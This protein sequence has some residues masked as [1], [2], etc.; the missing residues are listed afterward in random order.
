MNKDWRVAPLDAVVRVE[1]RRVNDRPEPLTRRICGVRRNERVDEDLI[2]LQHLVR[3]FSPMP[4][5]CGIVYD[6]SP[7]TRDHCD[8]Q[9]QLFSKLLFFIALPSWTAGGPPHRECANARPE[10]E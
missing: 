3:V 8:A 6:D 5:L 1:D 2:P 7:T 10:G 9:R 4:A